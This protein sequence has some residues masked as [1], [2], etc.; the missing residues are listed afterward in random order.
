MKK[1]VLK[2]FTI[3]AMVAVLPLSCKKPEPDPTP[4]PEPGPDPIETQAVTLTASSKGGEVSLD[5]TTTDAWT[6]EKDENYKWITPSAESGAAGE[7][8]LT[9]TATVN[10]SGRERSAM[11][12]VM[13][14]DQTAYE[15]L[16]S[17]PKNEIPLGEG[18]YAFLKQIVDGNMLGDA[19]PVVEDWFAFTGEEFSDT[20]IELANID[21]K[22]F[23]VQICLDGG[24]SPRMNNFPTE[25]VLLQCERIRLNNQTDLA[26]VEIP[27]VWNT[28]KLAHIALSHTMMTG[29]IPQGFADGASLSEIYF[30][31]TDFYGALPHIWASKSLE[32]CLLGSVNNTTFKGD[33][34]YAGDTE[35][36]YLGYLVPASLDVILNSERS[37]QSDCTQMKL[38]GVKEGHW[39]G[40]E[41]GWGQT[42]YEMFDEAAVPGD[43]T[44]WSEWRLLIGKAECDPDVWAWYF[45]N[46]GY[47]PVE[48]YKTHVP[49]E[50]KAWDQSV[51]DAFSAEAKI[52][53]DAGTPI[54]MTKFGKAPE[55]K[56]DDDIAAGNLIVVDDNVWGN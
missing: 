43:K 15:I 37:A 35:C 14:G 22:W 49:F 54:D 9:F 29:F 39:L 34:P 55:E 28:P 27:Q 41:E 38:G 20:G 18:D 1:N 2:L 31:D 45:S 19:T 5:I 13:Q 25:M 36:P 4:G 11:Y 21:G 56:H 26:G 52:C 46:M 48:N 7:T 47:T 12:Y 6:L 16:I 53:H 51:A 42:R 50:M 30:D 32:V 33:D 3:L 17:Q 24:D 10:D 40:F 8:T 23:V 44:T